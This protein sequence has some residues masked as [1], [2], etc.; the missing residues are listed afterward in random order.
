MVMDGRICL[1]FLIFLISSGQFCI[2]AD[3]F[4]AEK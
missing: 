2:D 4:K 1:I 3:T